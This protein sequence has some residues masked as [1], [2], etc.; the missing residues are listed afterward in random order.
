MPETEGDLPANAMEEIIERAQS[1]IQSAASSPQAKDAYKWEL[2][3]LIAEMQDLV[4]AARDSILD[5]Q[6]PATPN[7]TN[8]VR[9]I[10][11]QY[12][13]FLL[14]AKESKHQRDVLVDYAALAR[15]F[16]PG[17]LVRSLSHSHARAL[18]RVK[19]TGDRTDLAEKAT[20]LSWSVARLQSEINT[21]GKRSQHKTDTKGSPLGEWAKTQNS[22]WIC[23]ESQNPITNRQTM[24][25]L[26]LQPESMLDAAL[27]R[28][29]K[30]GGAAR[31]K[32]NGEEPEAPRVLRFENELTLFKWLAVRLDP[33]DLKAA[34]LMPLPKSTGN[35]VSQ[36][37][38]NNQITEK[39]T[40]RII[41]LLPSKKPLTDASSAGEVLAEEPTGDSPTGQGED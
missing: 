19:S 7:A 21:A 13:A 34:G 36:I 17:D 28:G 26:H 10:V 4:K 37:T 11:N 33:A 5:S 20:R 30:R 27:K 16:P 9:E 18:A 40:A 31:K 12:K 25:E 2:G 24:L 32:P 39:R 35:P 29:S 3:S 6:V 38:E 22:T 14:D 1:L 15:L 41:M 23:A 8:A